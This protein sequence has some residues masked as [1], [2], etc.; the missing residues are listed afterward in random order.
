MSRCGDVIDRAK[1]LYRIEFNTSSSSYQSAHNRKHP[2]APLKG[3]QKTPEDFTA[4]DAHAF[5]HP[6][7]DQDPSPNE[8]SGAAPEYPGSD[9]KGIDYEMRKEDLERR[10]ESVQQQV[11]ENQAAHGV[12]RENQKQARQ[13]IQTPLA[14]MPP[15]STHTMVQRNV[16]AASSQYPIDHLSHNLDQFFRQTEIWVGTYANSPVST[17]LQSVTKKFKERRMNIAIIN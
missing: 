2:T 9:S 12:V 5:D 6:Q 10:N 11:R 3:K 14:I 8:S 17:A 16:N 13:T 7:T 1:T 15:P 4:N